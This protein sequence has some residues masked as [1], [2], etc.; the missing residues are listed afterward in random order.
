MTQIIDSVVQLGT[1]MI[2]FGRSKAACGLTSGTTSGTWGSE[3]NA[4]ELSTTMTPR[5]A[6]TGAQTAET[7]SGT[8]NIAR[9]TPSKASG[10]SSWTVTWSPRIVTC[11]PAERADA[12]GRTSP[13]MSGRV[14]TI[15]HMVVP[16]A[17]VAP[18][19]ARVGRA[20][21]TRGDDP[22]EPPA[23]NVALGTA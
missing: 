20:V 7:S 3:R 16:T 4:P 18:T 23:G 17:P 21:L 11:L 12:I 9:S 1:E 13:Q 15:S 14:E 22:P 5:S 6:A 19:I 2:P 10:V 8:S